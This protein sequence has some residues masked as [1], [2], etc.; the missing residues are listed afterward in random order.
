MDRVVLLDTNVAAAPIHQYLEGAGFEVHVVGRN[1]ADYLAKAAANYVDL[2]Y[3][4]VEATLALVE[5]LG[6]T[7]LVPGCNDLSYE[8]CAA[9]SARRPF[10]GIDPMAVV[11]TLGNKQD[12]RRYA[13]RND[14]PAPRQVAEA[15]AVAG[16]P[17]IVKPVDA[18]SGRGVTALAAPTADDVAAALALARRFSATGACLIEEF[19]TGQLYSHTAFLGPQGVVA[20]FIVEEHGSINPFTV[21]T[22]CVV[23]DFDPALLAEV[24]AAIERIA[25]DLKL[26][27]GLIHT[28]FIA[29]DGRFWIVE[30]TRRCPGDLYSLLIELSTGFAYAENYA[31]PFL[32]LPFRDSPRQA[33]AIMRHTISLRAPQTFEALRFNRPLQ[34]ERFVP[35]SLAGDRVAQAPFARIGILFARTEPGAPLAEL[36]RATLEGQLYSVLGREL[37]AG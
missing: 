37:A 21:D 12:F 31:R 33:G 34:V 3:S 6:A 16:R 29:A 14:I 17:V 9:I 28:Q 27:S 32:G 7:Y 5:R 23:P 36:M 11:R 24:R 25:R 19:V 35:Q 4:D 2:D 15:D 13:A 22:S 26:T 1:P 10:P 30:I 20:D 8:T 18:Y